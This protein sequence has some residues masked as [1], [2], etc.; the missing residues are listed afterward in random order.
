ME[1]DDNESIFQDES[2]D[3]LSYI[4]QYL[5]GNA[6]PPL[7]L[8]EL[9][10]IKI[11][12][13]KPIFPSKNTLLKEKLKEVDAKLKARL[14]EIEDE[15]S[16]LFDID[17][18]Y[19]EFHSKKNKQKRREYRTKYSS[20]QHDKLVDSWEEYV[21]TKNIGVYFF[22]WLEH[23]HEPNLATPSQSKLDVITKTKWIKTDNTTINSS[24][25]HIDSIL[26][27]HKGSSITASPFKLPTDRSDCRQIVEQVNY[28]NQCLKVIGRQLDKIESALDDGTAC[29]I[30]P[31]S[32][33]IEKPLI[34]LPEKRSPISLD[35]S[36]NV[37]KIENI[38]TKLI[39]KNEP[40]TPRITVVSQTHGNDSSQSSDCQSSDCQSSDSEITKLQEQFTD[41][42]VDH[43]IKRLINPGSSITKNWYSRPTPV[44]MQY[45]ENNF[46]NQFSVSSTKLYEWNIDGLSE[47]Q[48]L[49][50]LNHMSMVANSYLSNTNLNQPQIV[51]LLTSGFTGELKAW[52]DKYLNDESRQQVIH[53]V[54]TDENGIPIFENEHGIHDGVYTLIYTIIKHFIGQPSNITSRIHDQLSNLHCP[55]LSDFRWYKDVFIFKVMLRDDCTKPFWKEKFIN[56][57]LTYL[58]IK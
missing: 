57:L 12:L 9:G 45:E 52:W 50:K 40:A 23:I 36:Q 30:P 1:N 18:L 46:L 51:E 37:Q 32:K 28:T 48:I 16:K 10:S 43:N 31:N 2:D 24:H 19:E 58:L 38:L 49:E 8:T 35:Q 27:N 53:A 41:L 11:P 54:Q 26:I 33:H 56:G 34:N 47:H 25:P 4:K 39:I 15:K 21:N 13:S 29:C 7:R 5:N 20:E 14:K 42:K 6:S 3:E 44:D 55:T 22:V 17:E